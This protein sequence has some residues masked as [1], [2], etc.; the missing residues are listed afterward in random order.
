M[1][2]ELTSGILLLE[3]FHRVMVC[4][5]EVM[6][7]FARKCRKKVLIRVI[8]HFQT[9]CL[10]RGINGRIGGATPG[11][12]LLGLRVVQCRNVTPL[13]RAEDRDVVLVSPG[14]DLGLPLAFSRSLMKNLIL[15]FLFP[16]CFAIFFF[17]FNRTGYDLM[18]NSIVVEDSVRTRNNNNN[19]NNRLNQQQ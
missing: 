9:Y 10:Q 4:V 1:A 18:C 5:F 3:F 17:R 2:L 8:W 14:T 6:P 16:V 15:A 19:Q 12:A 11:K 13:D 7:T